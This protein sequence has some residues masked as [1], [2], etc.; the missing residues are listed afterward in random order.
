MMAQHFALLSLVFMMAFVFLF[1]RIHWRN[2]TRR[3]WQVELFSQDEME[4]LLKIASACQD[5]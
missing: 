2:T 5:L 4:Q 3:L 1:D